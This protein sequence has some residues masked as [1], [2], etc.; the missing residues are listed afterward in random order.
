MKNSIKTVYAPFAGGN[1]RSRTVIVKGLKVGNKTVKSA[2]VGILPN[3]ASTIEPMKTQGG[4][5]GMQCFA[6]RQLS[7]ILSGK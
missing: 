5:L 3:D 1:T 4:L 7:S 6:D 2:Y